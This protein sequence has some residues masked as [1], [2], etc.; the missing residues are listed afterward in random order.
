MIRKWITPAV[1]EMIREE[2]QRIKEE[3]CWAVF[4]TLK[5]A[6]AEMLKGLTLTPLLTSGKCAQASAFFFNALVLA[7]LY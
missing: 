7:L 5:K 4:E 1:L 3:I 6:L 2:E